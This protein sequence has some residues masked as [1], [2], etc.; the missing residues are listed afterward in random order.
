MNH[1]PTGGESF[2]DWLKK[3]IPALL[4]IV[5]GDESLPTDTARLGNIEGM[6]AD[7]LKNSEDFARAIS[8]RLKKHWVAPFWKKLRKYSL[9]RRDSW[10]TPGHNGGNSFLRSIF[11]RPFHEAFAPTGKAPITFTADLSVSVR[12]LGDI[13][14]PLAERNPMADAMNRAAKYFGAEDTLFATNGTS[15][16]N[17]VMLMALLRP[18]ET[19]LLDR[20]CHK[21]VHQAVVTSGAFPV[22][23]SPPF[24]DDL[25]IWLPLSLD[26]LN[27]FCSDQEFLDT[28]QP[29]MLVLTT[30]TYEGILYPV[31]EIA[32]TCYQK[33][34][35]LY[36]DEAWFP[37]WPIPSSL[38][39][40][41][42]KR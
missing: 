41:P 32:E 23:L 9:D 13:S 3:H 21:S 12:E 18:G 10:H 39:S 5:L 33:G 28:L 2:C 42:F 29:R 20:N 30:C 37:L 19:V 24:H 40:G 36:S 8:G 16:S 27:V 14:E 26:H 22:Y 1:A 11:L 31:Q 17:K 4:I 38:W 35:L 25:G 34:I 7:L 6:S 15:T